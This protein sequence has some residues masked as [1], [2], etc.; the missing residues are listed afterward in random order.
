MTGVP[1]HL[2]WPTRSG[3]TELSD[4]DFEDRCAIGQ[5]PPEDII[6]TRFR[7][8]LMVGVR[9]LIE[10]P[11]EEIALRWPAG[12]GEGRGFVG[13]IE[14][15]EDG[16]D[17]GRI[18]EEGEDPHLAGAGGT[19]QRQLVVDAREQDGPADSERGGALTRRL[20]GNG[21][22]GGIAFGRRRLGPAEDHDVG[23]EP[24]IGSQHAVVAM[25]MD[26]RGRDEGT[27]AK[28]SSA[29]ASRSSRGVSSSSVRPWMSGLGK[30]AP[31]AVRARVAARG[32]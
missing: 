15:E 14:V 6:S 5:R 2:C 11:G 18:G 19:E 7:P 21:R 31:I 26:P 23:P 22:G 29:R 28:R 9:S 3:P 27:D 24:G 1:D 30:R 8:S 17:D 13:E 10:E 12:R 25:A 4:I 20:G 16:G 32:R